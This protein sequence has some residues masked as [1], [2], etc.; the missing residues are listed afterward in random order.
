MAF[1]SRSAYAPSTVE[2]VKTVQE[3]F[4]SSTGRISSKEGVSNYIED[5]IIKLNSLY[6]TLISLENSFYTKLNLPI[7]KKGILELRRRLNKLNNDKYF[8]YMNNVNEEEM[9]K[10]IDY[11]LTGVNRE[12]WFKT[13][14]EKSSFLDELMKDQSV[15]SYSGKEFV[16]LLNNYLKDT[17]TLDG[18]VFYFQK[19]QK[20]SRGLPNYIASLK[21]TKKKGKVEVDVTPTNDAPLI[22]AKMID[23]LTTATQSS[24]DRFTITGNVQQRAFDYFLNKI[25][26]GEIRQSM[27][28]MYQLYGNRFNTN[29]SPASIRGFFG[30]L[31]ALVAMDIL[32]NGNALPTGTL[33]QATGQVGKQIPIDLIV[34]DAGFQIKNYQLEDKM[35]TFHDQGSSFATVVSNTFFDDQSLVETI[36]EFFGSYQYNQP[37]ETA[38]PSYIGLYGRFQNSINNGNLEK[39][40]QANLDNLL[41]ISSQFSAKAN[42]QNLFNT[43]GFY[44]NTFF[45]V[46]KELI[47]ASAIVLALIETLRTE[48]KDNNFLTSSFVFETN[49]TNEPTWKESHKKEP[50]N[51]SARDLTKNFKVEYNIRMNPSYILKKALAIMN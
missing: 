19:G 23:R 41:R 12:D 24:W 1:S 20:Q 5:I 7:G 39:M 45:I 36:L 18:T 27:Q 47:P 34:A 28:K 15:V 13:V 10:A 35:I 6:Q 33:L 32:S 3:N 25:S 29:T 9:Q 22:P 44:Y 31:K 16:S 40:F 2:Q 48:N 26:D 37:I 50:Q 43:N 4:L 49:T 14:L 17:K 21:F 8:L 30:E 38:T 11:A 42:P 51:I 46:G